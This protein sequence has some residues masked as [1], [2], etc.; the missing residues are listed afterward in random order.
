SNSRHVILTL[1]LMPST[2]SVCLLLTLRVQQSGHPQL[3]SHNKRLLQ[4]RSVG[5]GRHVAHIN[6][7]WPAVERNREKETKEVIKRKKTAGQIVLIDKDFKWT[8][9]VFKVN[10]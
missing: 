4:I 7:I 9:Q 10:V 8:F 6:Q 3:L 5:L 2:P 1:A